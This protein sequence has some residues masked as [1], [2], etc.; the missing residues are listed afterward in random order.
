MEKVE[1][2]E[3][4]KELLER[5]KK[6][7]DSLFREC[8][9]ANNPYKKGDIITDHVESIS[10]EKISIYIGSYTEMPSCVYYGPLVKKDGTPFKNGK[11][12]Q[13]FQSNIIIKK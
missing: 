11:K 2:E 1:Y 10:I 7:V 4:K 5:H 6:E 8:A 13:I 3:K 12:A 9:L